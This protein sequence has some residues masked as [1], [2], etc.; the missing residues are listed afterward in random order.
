MKAKTLRDLIPKDSIYLLHFSEKIIDGD[1]R[2]NNFGQFVNY[3]GPAIYTYELYDRQN[4]LNDCHNTDKTC[5]LYVYEA[6]TNEIIESICV[7]YE[8]WESN[9]GLSR[10]EAND[11]L[12]KSE[13]LREW[14]EIGKPFLDGRSLE[15]ILKKP[16]VMDMQELLKIVP[17]DEDTKR[18]KGTKDI[19]LGEA[20]SQTWG[21]PYPVYAIVN[22]CCLLHPTEIERVLDRF[23]DAGIKW[24]DAFTT[25]NHA[26]Y[27][28]YDRKIRPVEVINCTGKSPEEIFSILASEGLVLSEVQE[29]SEFGGC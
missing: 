1:F 4:F 6:Q 28:G 17:E 27:V 25:Y 8:N 10:D 20:Q 29:T 26:I 13:T 5:Y 11:F 16:L 18:L 12:M 19:I 2:L 3:V 22:Q 23:C 15:D 21:F 7:D 9:T 14:Y 24:A